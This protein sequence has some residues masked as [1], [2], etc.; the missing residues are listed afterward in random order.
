MASQR[1]I[2][3]SVVVKAPPQVVF[4]ALTQASELERWFPTTAKTDPRPGGEYAFTW[5]LEGESATGGAAMSLDGKFIDVVPDRKVSYSWLATEKDHPTTVEWALTPVEGGTRVYLAHSGYGYG[6]EWD[7]SWDM[8]EPGWTKFVEN[9]RSVV[10]D[11]V[12][13][14]PSEIGIKMKT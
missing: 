9:L 2:H 6:D 4:R 5:A 7:T 10:D 1:T 3:K 13:K 8:V 14:R 12:D 11:G